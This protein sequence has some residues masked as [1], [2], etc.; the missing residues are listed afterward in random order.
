[1]DHHV[2]FLLRDCCCSN[3]M[4]DFDLLGVCPSNAIDRAEFSDAIGGGNYHFLQKA[5]SG[6]KQKDQ[7]LPTPGESLILEYASAA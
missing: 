7:S 3:Y 4:D 5:T 6:R 1:M 2:L